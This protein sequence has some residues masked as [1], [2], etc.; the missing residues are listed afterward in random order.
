MESARMKR[1]AMKPATV[2]IRNRTISTAS[3]TPLTP[4]VSAA[5]RVTCGCHRSSPTLWEVRPRA[6][7]VSR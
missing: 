2:T 7:S 3:A 4:P 6:D 5:M 1:L